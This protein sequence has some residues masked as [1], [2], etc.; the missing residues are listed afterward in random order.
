MSDSSLLM[1]LEEV[2][3]KTLKR[4]EE[5]NEKVQCIYGR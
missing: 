2:R 1:L 4:L 3:G 5:E